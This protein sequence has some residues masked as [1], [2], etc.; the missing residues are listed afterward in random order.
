MGTQ[1]ISL[2]AAK[3]LLATYQPLFVID[4]LWADGSTLSVC[5]HAVAVNGNS[6]L[7]RVSAQQI[8]TTQ[9]LSPTGIDIPPNVKITLADADKSMWQIEST[10]KF[11][12]ARMTVTFLFYDFATGNWSDSVI[13]F[14]GRCD[15]PQVTEETLIVSASYIL[16]LQAV[17]L[18]QFPIQVQCPKLKPLTSAQVALANIQGS[19][20]F[21]CG[22]QTT[23]DC[24]HTQTGCAAQNTTPLRFGGIVYEV[25]PASRSESYTS[26]QWLN[27]LISDPCDTK[28]GD[29][30]PIGYGTGWVNCLNL[31]TFPD[32]NS[33]RGEAI[34]CEGLIQNIRQVVVAGE[35]LPPA[36]DITGTVHYQVSD[37]LFRYNVVSRGDRTGALNTDT[38]WN[39]QGDP[40]GSLCVIEWV[41]YNAITASTPSIQAL[42]DFPQVQ[43]Y[44]PILNVVA[45]VLTL[46]NNAPNTNIA[47]NPPYQVQ[48]IANSNGVLN[49]SFNLTSWTYGPPGTVTLSGTTASGTGG[50]IGYL[51]DSSDYAW[52][53]FDV[54]RRAG[55]QIADL[56]LASFALASAYYAEMVPFTTAQNK[57][58]SSDITYSVG[59]VVLYTVD[60]QYY[61]SLADANVN[62][63]PNLEFVLHGAG[64]TGNDG[65]WA[66]TTAQPTTSSTT[67]VHPR[68]TCSLVLRSRRTAADILQGM[69]RGC[70]SHLGRNLTTGQISLIPHGTIAQ[71]QPTLP[72]GS[73]Y[74]SAVNSGFAA[75]S[76]DETSIARDKQKR[77]T[78]QRASRAGAGVPNVVTVGFSNEDNN[79]SGDSVKVPD[80]DDITLMGQEIQGSITVDGCNALDRA[81]RVGSIFLSEQLDGD[82]WEFVT[83]AKAVKL[84]VG[85]IILLNSIKYGFTLQPFRVQGV[86]PEMNWRTCKITANLHED[87]WY[88]DDLSLTGSANGT[89]RASLPRLPWPWCPNAVAPAAGDAL[90]GA[91]A[92]T[93]S[94]QISYAKTLGDGSPQ[95]VAL[96]GGVEP[97]NSPDPTLLPPVLAQQGDTAATGGSLPGSGTVIWIAAAST[98]AAGLPG[99]VSRP[100]QIVIAQSGSTNTGTAPVWF[101]DPNGVG[102]KIYAGMNP[103]KL[104]LQSSGTGAP[105]QAIILTA[106]VGPGEA[107]PDIE[108]DQ[109][110]IVPRWIPH[111]GPFANTVQVSAGTFTIT[112]AGWTTNQWLGYD[113]MLLAKADGSAVPVASFHITGNTASAL[114]VTPDPAA[115]GLV[116]GDLIGMLSKPAVSGLTLT[117]AKWANTLSGLGT[118]LT[119]HAEKGRYVRFIA[120]PGRGYRYQIA[121][122]TATAITVI[123]DRKS[124]V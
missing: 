81:N 94:L 65:W 50:F 30:A 63:V 17:S 1:S 79:F 23:V 37:P 123:G 46:A 115:L 18:P 105:P 54:L 49:N 109:L 74:S 64:H 88:A 91:T 73:N 75:Y 95:P 120:G 51:T 114:T 53:I 12:G 13:P 47:G 48:I 42:C 31:G 55:A 102:W 29:Y 25:P 68:Y 62:N 26:G 40:H 87:A 24:N 16:A 7:A 9:A 110:Q 89:K 44:A 84:S 124:V 60:G 103:S 59:D 96:I 52:A 83:T 119:P 28:Y 72:D 99:P 80:P 27:T 112:G 32:A 77:S 58:Y 90:Y 92:F 93:F 8:D 33:T 61:V 56:D 101:W 122:N 15:R 82:L 10:K 35:I 38:P 21:P 98:D 22:S 3:E 113:C 20:Y 117:D 70:N 104:T 6:Y 78:L 34:V 45:G 107:Q 2:N 14:V 67:S 4:F 36:T 76:F 11:R 69:L 111:V 5:T 118:G 116:S 66:L 97:V 121:D 85:Q 86:A 19:P 108:F 57:D 71:Q 41:V 106:L 100:C 39:S 43:A